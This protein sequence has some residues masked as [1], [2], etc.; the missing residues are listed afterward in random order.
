MQKPSIQI[1]FRQAL[2]L[3]PGILWPFID[4]AS[5]DYFQQEANF[6]IQVTLDDRVHELKGF[7]SVEY[8][9]NSPAENNPAMPHQ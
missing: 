8:I 6:K 2:L 7:E 1:I 9:N 4:A 3:I 5:Q